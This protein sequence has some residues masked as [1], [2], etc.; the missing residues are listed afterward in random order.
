M[1]AIVPLIF[2]DQALRVTD[3][4]GQP[5]FVL[6]DACAMLG[7]KNPTV[8]AKPLDETEKAKVFIGQ[9]SEATVVSLP[10]LLTLIVRC[11]GALKPG[12]AAYRVRKWVTS[13]VVPT[14]M[15]TGT[16]GAPIAPANLDDN[17]TLRALLMGRMDKLDELQPKADAL[18]RITEARGS[19]CVT[20]AARVGALTGGGPA[21]R[22]TARSAHRSNA[23]YP[24]STARTLRGRRPGPAGARRGCCGQGTGR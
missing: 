9:G 11:R 3:R 1:N 7:I 18:A 15:R 13:D 22:G 24:R 12:T 8:A 20:D 21:R 23:C 14:I 6:A 19:L 4:D 17:A 5:W 10:G 16:Y 2:D